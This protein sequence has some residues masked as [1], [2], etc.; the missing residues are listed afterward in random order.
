MTR[1]QY[2]LRQGS[3]DLE[4]VLERRSTVSELLRW[5]N[6]TLIPSLCLLS[7]SSLVEHPDDVEDDEREGKTAQGPRMT[8]HI[9]RSIG[10][11]VDLPGDDTPQVGKG[12][13]CT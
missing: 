4:L 2:S 3:P 8:E 7:F 12:Q 10:R 11:S 9:S 1:R 13:L 5:H 6:N